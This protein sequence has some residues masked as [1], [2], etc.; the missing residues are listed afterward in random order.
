VAAIFG[1]YFI[2]K[3]F[4]EHDKRLINQA[5]VVARMLAPA[6]EYGVVSENIEFLTSLLDDAL[7]EKDVIS[8]S[9]TDLNERPIIT[10]LN[11]SVIIHD[12]ISY[13]HPIYLSQIDILDDDTES[14]TSDIIQ[15]GWIDISMSRQASE[16]EKNRLLFDMLAFVFS[17]VLFAGV[18][19]YRMSARLS[20]PIIRMENAIRKIENGVY[21]INLVESGSQEIISLANGIN[22]MAR[23]IDSLTNKQQETIADATRSLT[24]SLETIEDQNSELEAANDMAVKASEVKSKFLANMSHELRTPLN[25]ITGFIDVLKSTQLSEHQRE[26]LATIKSSSELLMQI[27]NDILD[28]SKIEAGMLDIEN[29]DYNINDCIEEILVLLSPSA[30][31]KGLYVHYNL[32]SAITPYVVGDELRIKQVLSNL[33]SNAIKFTESGSI[34]VNANLNSDEDQILIEVVDTGIGLSF[35]FQKNLFR[36]FSQEDPSI[37]RN[38]GGTGLGLA[39]SKKLIELMGGNIG[40]TSSSGHGT[41]FWFTLPYTLG[42]IS[43][44]IKQKCLDGK[45]ILLIS[46]RHRSL[47]SF[48]NE[49]VQQGAKTTQVSLNEINDISDS[50]YRSYD[51]AIIRYTSTQTTATDSIIETLSSHHKLPTLIISNHPEQTIGGQSDENTSVLQEYARLS[52]IL[53]ALC[54]LIGVKNTQNPEQEDDEIM[55]QKLLSSGPMNIL[56]TDDNSINR[57]LITSLLTSK[58]ILVDEAESGEVAINMCNTQLYDIIFMDIHMPGISGVDTVKRL[59]A[60]NNPNQ[61]SCIV[62]LTADTLPETRRTIVKE[63]FDSILIKPINREILF[64]MVLNSIGR[65][66]E[67]SQAAYTP[68]KHQSSVYN[69]DDAMRKTGNNRQ[70]ATELLEM[71]FTELPDYKSSLT[72][73]IEALNYKETRDVA[74]KL[75]GSASYC[76]TGNLAKASIALESAALK[77]DKALVDSTFSDVLNAISELELVKQNLLEQEL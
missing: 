12:P 57:H 36:E 7:R 77:E 76:S 37:T 48:S 13:R 38:Y 59:R 5:E 23:S 21:S 60:T 33:I 75:S 71:F 10:R 22:R 43:Q 2:N 9:V 51:C 56:V 27:I 54:R 74:H 70:L 25:G 50:Q 15:I 64:K 67:P 17:V 61:N 11:K 8:L 47:S 1:Y 66:E 3:Y 32:D 69:M 44:P 63:G 68:N 20:N 49:A 41:R 39:V 65:V 46:D 42:T 55:R 35:D 18:F 31:E 14:I 24:E 29:L 19:A 52:S 62:A 40:V 30:Y 53:N 4:S 34:T 45:S 28:F 16:T 6:S 72:Q 58:N 26:V 73:Y